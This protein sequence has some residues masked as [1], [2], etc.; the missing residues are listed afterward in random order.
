MN[1]SIGVLI[2]ASAIVYGTPLLYAAL[3]ELLAERSG[4]LNLGV[5]GMMA[6]GAVA[7]FAAADIF[8]TPGAGVLASALAGA[9]MAGL[10]G[11]VTLIF[12]ANQVASGLALTLFGLGLSGL[13]GTPYVGRPGAGIAKVSIPVLSDLP[14]VGPILFGED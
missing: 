4:V 2:A 13:V 10:F 12:R 7:G 5:E 11:V 1:N 6:V 3:G 9:L 8:G 14:V